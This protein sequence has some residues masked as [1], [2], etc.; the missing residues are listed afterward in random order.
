MS[1]PSRTP[2]LCQSSPVLVI[3]TTT[4]ALAL[5]SRD[6]HSLLAWGVS[7]TPSGPL[8]VP[9]SPAL[10]ALKMSVGKILCCSPSFSPLQPLAQSQQASLSAAIFAFRPLQPSG[11]GSDLGTPASKPILQL[12]CIQSFPRNHLLFLCGTFSSTV[13]CSSV[14]GNSHLPLTDSGSSLSLFLQSVLSQLTGCLHVSDFPHVLYHPQVWPHLPN[15][16]YGNPCPG[17]GSTSFTGASTP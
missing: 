6:P 3:T 7:L 12:S 2:R 13:P 14:F 4:P 15:W 8:T 10:Q 17:T 5:P 1:T 9:L 11:L 16:P